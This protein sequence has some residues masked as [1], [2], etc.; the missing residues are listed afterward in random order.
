MKEFLDSLDGEIVVVQFVVPMNG[1]IRKARRGPHCLVELG[2][3]GAGGSRTYRFKVLVI[4]LTRYLE[5][6]NLMNR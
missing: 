1:V 3:S 5:F 4:F 6:A 2:S